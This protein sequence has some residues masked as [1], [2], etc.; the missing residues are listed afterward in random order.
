MPELRHRFGVSGAAGVE[1]R[2]GRCDAGR[3]KRIRTR[4][5]NY[6]E[7]ELWKYRA[8]KDDGG[9]ATEAAVG[10]GATGADTAAD[11]AVGIRPTLRWVPDH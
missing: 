8:E 9:D 6:F 1:E 4:A 2:V 7:D 5:E 11:R 3:E 10:A